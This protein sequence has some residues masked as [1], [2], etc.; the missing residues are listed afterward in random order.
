MS[1]RSTAGSRRRLEGSDTLQ[2]CPY[3]G[4]LLLVRTLLRYGR[5][6]RCQDEER[7]RRSEEIYKRCLI[8]S[9]RIATGLWNANGGRCVE[10]T[11][12]MLGECVGEVRRMLIEEHIR[13]MVEERPHSIARM[14]WLEALEKRDSGATLEE[15]AAV[16]G[17]VA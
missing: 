9:K 16:S 1:R 8:C 4:G 2:N 5:C 10:C 7:A 14:L 11:H 12:G 17:D 3:C 13:W 6:A 15:D